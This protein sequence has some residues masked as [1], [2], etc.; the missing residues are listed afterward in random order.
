MSEQ[1]ELPF[2]PPLDRAMKRAEILRTAEEYI[3]KDRAATH[4]NMEDNFSTIAAYWT[5][6][7]GHPVTALDVA[8][9]MTLVKVARIKSG[10]T[11]LDNYVDA[12]GYMGC[13]GELADKLPTPSHRQERSG[14][15]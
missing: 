10:P 3:T 12:A 13:G 14:D 5:T 8:V 4:G 9:M 15:H 6:H 1:L 7:L 2:D 11:N